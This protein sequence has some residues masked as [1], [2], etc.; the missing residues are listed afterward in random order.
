MKRVSMRQSR[1]GGAER[2]VVLA[3]CLPMAA[4]LLILGPAGASA[5]IALRSPKPRTV[6]ETGQKGPPPCGNVTPNPNPQRYRPGET[7]MVEWDETV[8]HAG[9]FRI[10]FGPAGTDFPAPVTKND[11]STT[12]PIFLDGIDEKPTGAGGSG[13][14]HRRMITFPSQPCAACTLQVIQIMTVDPPY[15]PG[16]R[17]DIYYQCADIVLEGAPIPGGPVAGGADGGSRLDAG[18]RA[19]AAPPP[20]PPGIGGPPT[21]SPVGGAGGAGGSGGNQAT[22]R[23]PG[24]FEFGCSVAGGSPRAP[25]ISTVALLAVLLGLRRRRAVT[26]R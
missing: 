16:P 18:S 2:R 7:I 11:T 21:P 15:N 19:D 13:T 9:H 24:F 3:R 17:E 20:L 4:V 5:H 14:T 26:R 6:A 22:P 25:A 1:S 23:G 10:A 12:L 8:G